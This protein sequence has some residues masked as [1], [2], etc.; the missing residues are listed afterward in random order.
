MQNLLLGSSKTE[1]VPGKA[2]KSPAVPT[3][4]SGKASDTAPGKSSFL[5]NL[6]FAVEEIEKP[7]KILK[8]ADKKS[9][10]TK[11]LVK[12]TNKIAAKNEGGLANLIKTEE[13]GENSLLK[14]FA[15][16]VENSEQ[17]LLSATSQA[18]E[19]I[20]QRFEQAEKQVAES[21]QSNQPRK[22]SDILKLA[23]TK[24]IPLAK[25][26][27]DEPGKSSVKIRFVEPIEYKGTDEKPTLKISPDLTHAN[28]IMLSKK[29]SEGKLTSQHTL[30]SSKTPDMPKA[31]QSGQLKVNNV[32]EEKP[33][34]AQALAEEKTAQKKT[35]LTRVSAVSSGMTASQKSEEEKLSLK[36]LDT[37]SKDSSEAKRGLQ[38]TP[39]SDMKGTSKMLLQ[40]EDDS[41]TAGVQNSEV[42]PSKEKTSNLQV[43]I[44]SSLPKKLK[45]SKGENSQP[46]HAKQKPASV[47]KQSLEAKHE[48]LTG[49]VKE[50]TLQPQKSQTEAKNV[51]VV[52]EETS[53]KNPV[54]LEADTE[55]EISETK[56]NP[57]EANTKSEAADTRT[58]Q[59]NNSVNT[60]T[61]TASKVAETVK[62]VETV[63]EKNTISEKIEAKSTEVKTVEANNKVSDEQSVKTAKKDSID[64]TQKTEEKSVEESTET[65][66]KTK[67]KMT[68]NQQQQ[69]TLH[70]KE[71]MTP[72][73]DL[74][75][76][77][78]SL[79]P[80]RQE[81][82]TIS[83]KASPLQQ[84]IQSEPKEVRGEGPV[85]SVVQPDVKIKESETVGKD[86]TMKTA[87]GIKADTETAKNTVSSETGV[88]QGESD[89]L[90]SKADR[91]RSGES[92]QTLSGNKTAEPFQPQR[93]QIM[94]PL[95]EDDVKAKTVK[96]GSK[97]A[98]KSSFS[99]SE[100]EK[101]AEPVQNVRQESRPVT[102]DNRPLERGQMQPMMQNESFGNGNGGSGR[103]GMGRTAEG[104]TESGKE[105][106]KSTSGFEEILRE[107]SDNASGIKA[108]FSS[109]SDLVQRMAQSRETIR[110]FSMQ[111]SEEVKNYKPP[112]SRITLELNPEKL[113]SVE[114]TITTRGNNVQ[115][116]LNSNP[117]A[118][119]MLMQN[120]MEFK[121]ALSNLG[122]N[123]VQMNFSSGGGGQGQ[124]GQQE[125][126]NGNGFYHFDDDMEGEQIEQ[127]ELILPKYI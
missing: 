40:Q 32:I 47:E 24:E 80:S 84:L 62:G 41:K 120:N 46:V 85:K 37:D 34:L 23:Q 6:M 60:E 7:E 70:V 99:P 54:A 88:K 50:K 66:Q 83:K 59:Q 51:S 65:A 38:K 119:M 87:P 92:R 111:L 121:N 17:K 9:D 86:S 43:E 107:S 25:V 10:P 124:K 96:Q 13:K 27:Y 75:A 72:T 4:E 31:L 76:V 122:F 58:T 56:K 20:Q 89:D 19:K 93:S 100:S 45:S 63:V 22:L 102:T 114:V 94:E 115:V 91:K 82:Q 126:R 42:R 3:G 49:D 110:N 90:V 125:Q 68:P 98:I 52:E 77:K 73:Q 71:R 108:D 118:M 21:A 16:S 105:T 95:A 1:A 26:Q 57:S 117:S 29:S 101:P 113:G 103:E 33:L 28:N 12:E 104:R 44:D 53:T 106:Q 11:M 67:P 78:E 112:I 64:V 55:I 5:A 116:S 123:D 8:N 18:K 35:P 14:S 81:A 48:I 36:L 15:K 74:F 30:V 97:D 61:S 109:K 39:V 2:L 69:Q 79:K 127:I